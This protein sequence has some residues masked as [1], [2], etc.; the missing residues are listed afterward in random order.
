MKL[1]RMRII[2]INFTRLVA[3]LFLAR[4]S[5]PLAERPCCP[6]T[7]KVWSTLL[8]PQHTCVLGKDFTT[9]FA[10]NLSYICR[11]HKSVHPLGAHGWIV[12]TDPRSLLYKGV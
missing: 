8:E 12:P 5:D 11:R 10:L 3:P 6:L 2:F 4:S 7:A 9:D 1:T